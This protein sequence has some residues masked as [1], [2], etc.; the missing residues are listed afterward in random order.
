M[1]K[2]TEIKAFTY[3]EVTGLKMYLKRI[4]VPIGLVQK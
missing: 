4:W 1:F 3:K 2:N